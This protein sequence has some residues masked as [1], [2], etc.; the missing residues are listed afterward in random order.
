V[1]TDC[2]V[3]RVALETLGPGVPGQDVAVLVER[4]NGVVVDAFDKQAIQ[5]ACLVGNA[6]W[7]LLLGCGTRIEGVLANAFFGV[8]VE[9]LTAISADRRVRPGPAL[10]PSKTCDSKASCV[11]QFAVPVTCRSVG[12]LRHRF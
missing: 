1:L 11:L 6:A 4:E 5:V 12:T 7:R 9:L 10:V 8:P 2:F 3:G